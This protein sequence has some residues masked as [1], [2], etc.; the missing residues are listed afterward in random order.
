MRANICVDLLI[1]KSEICVVLDKPYTG[2]NYEFV[3]FTFFFSKWLNNSPILRE[4]N[5]VF[6]EKY[7][8]VPEIFP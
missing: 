8:N 4:K 3:F 7:K 1:N 5:V 2:K 6:L